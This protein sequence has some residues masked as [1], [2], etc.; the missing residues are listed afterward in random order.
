ME[1]KGSSKRIE[2]FEDLV[3]WQKARILTRE[4]Y[5]VTQKE[6]FRKRFRTVRANATRCSVYHVEYCRRI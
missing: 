6:L 2:R 3:A 4:L 5:Q 1:N